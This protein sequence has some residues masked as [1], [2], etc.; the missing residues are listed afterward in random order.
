[1]LMAR[2]FWMIRRSAGLFSGEGPPALTAIVISLPIFANAL[3]ILSQRANIVALRVSK[4]RP[5]GLPRV[6][7]GGES[8]EHDTTAAHSTRRRG[9]LHTWVHGAAIGASRHASRSKRF[10]R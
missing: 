5:M 6:G 9:R 7:G 2:A 4:M 10:A 8:A 3:D 1:M